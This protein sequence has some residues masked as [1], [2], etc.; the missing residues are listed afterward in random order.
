MTKPSVLADQ[1]KAIKGKDA[2]KRKGAF[3]KEP[4]GDPSWYFFGEETR[5]RKPLWQKSKGQKLFREQSAADQIAVLSTIDPITKVKPSSADANVSMEPVGGKPKAQLGVAIP[6]SVFTLYKSL[7]SG[8]RNRLTGSTAE[9]AKLFNEAYA[10]KLPGH[11]KTASYLF[12]TESLS[13]KARLANSKALTPKARGELVSNLSPAEAF[14]LIHNNKLTRHENPI[15]PTE[16]WK[17][18]ILPPGIIVGG[19]QA[20]WRAGSRA[21]N[22]LGHA[23]TNNY[24][25][26]NTTIDYVKSLDP[27]HA[28]NLLNNHLT[29]AF[30]RRDAKENPNSTRRAAYKAVQILVNLPEESRAIALGQML[31]AKPDLKNQSTQNARYAFASIPSALPFYKRAI[32]FYNPGAA[33]QAAILNTLGAKNI[34]QFDVLFDSISIGDST[35][36]PKRREQDKKDVMA[37]VTVAVQQ[38][39]IEHLLREDRLQEAQKALDYTASKGERTAEILTHLADQPPLKI[40]PKSFGNPHDSLLEINRAAYLMNNMNPKDMRKAWKNLDGETKGKIYKNLNIPAKQNVLRTKGWAGAL[41]STVKQNKQQFDKDSVKNQVEILGADKA[42]IKRFFMRGKKAD[43]K[44]ENSNKVFTEMYGAAKYEELTKGTSDKWTSLETILQMSADGQLSFGEDRGKIAFEAL[45]DPLKQDD[46]SWQFDLIEHMKHNPKVE[47]HAFNLLTPN[48]QIAF[49]ARQY[50]VDALDFPKDPARAERLFNS[51]TDPNIQAKLAS[52]PTLSARAVELLN[53]IKSPDQLAKVLSSPNIG[54]LA[55]TYM[56]DPSVL[57]Q[58]LGEVLSKVRDTATFNQLLSS[59]NDLDIRADVWHQIPDSQWNPRANDRN[60]AFKNLI[61]N[62]KKGDNMNFL[63]KLIATKDL[64]LQNKLNLEKAA[65]KLSSTEIQIALQKMKGTDTGKEFFK[66][67][68]YKAKK[69]FLNRANP[70]DRQAYINELK[71][72]PSEMRQFLDDAKP[73]ARSDCI[74][75]MDDKERKDYVTDSKTKNSEAQAECFNK[76]ED[77]A[78]KSDALLRLQAANKHKTANGLFKGIAKVEDKA[79]V[80]QNISTSPRAGPSSAAKLLAGLGTPKDR[81]EVLGQMVADGDPQAAADTFGQLSPGLKIPAWR[82]IHPDHR[83]AFYEKLSAADQLIMAK[84][85]IDRAKQSKS[86]AGYAEARSLLDS[87]KKGDWQPDQWNALSAQIPAPKTPAGIAP[88]APQMGNVPSPSQPTLSA[89]VA[90]QPGIVPGVPAPPVDAQA[91]LNPFKQREQEEKAQQQLQEQK[92]SSQLADLQ[93]NEDAVEQQA[94]AEQQAA[95]HDDMAQA[96]ADA[97]EM[98]AEQ[99]PGFDQGLPE[100]HPGGGGGDDESAAAEEAAAADPGNAG[101]DPTAGQPAPVQ[102]GADEVVPASDVGANA[103]APDDANAIASVDPTAG[104]PA[105]VQPGVEAS[106][107]SLDASKFGPP[108]DRMTAA[109][110][111]ALLQS[112]QPAQPELDTSQGMAPAP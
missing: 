77:T 41:G 43:F 28:G 14:D 93:V 51:I 59:I 58:K 67:L 70:A 37:A 61:N 107:H 50:S 74:K 35:T 108:A 85:T 91:L 8:W 19:I 34:Q 6:K 94:A 89:S 60:T 69:E 15:I 16:P 55:S 2:D 104:K 106:G 31:G 52:D 102:P 75:V 22:A 97:Q 4:D 10:S 25:L 11:A 9:R 38:K 87:A 46:P 73:E 88:P 24:F 110:E 12:K 68:S 72:N 18:R 78:E 101:V 40:P 27:K 32:P 20:L 1:F 63:S 36:N 65:S 95:E 84:D 80:L 26:A 81:G 62:A 54:A 90:P 17:R 13:T 111:P 30:R 44:R 64:S 7:D 45:H 82:Q 92:Q 3:F 86:E 53:S 103:A 57:P 71:S 21:V 83:Q 76:I 42:L 29:E 100:P 5:N 98:G 39:Y 23:V 47:A 48:N 99:Q 49:I 56:N 105:P 66:F 112:Q 96:E 33:A 79:A 109:A